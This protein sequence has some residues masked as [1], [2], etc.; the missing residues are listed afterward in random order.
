MYVEPSAGMQVCKGSPNSLI[1]EAPR[2]K[3]L[4]TEGIHKLIVDNHYG[5]SLKPGAA[6]VSAQD[7]A[8]VPPYSRELFGMNAW[9]SDFQLL[10]EI[11]DACRFLVQQTVAPPIKSGTRRERLQSQV[12]CGNRTSCR[13]SCEFTSQWAPPETWELWGLT[14]RHI[15]GLVVERTF[16][17]H[18]SLT[19]GV[20]MFQTGNAT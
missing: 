18:Y 12:K 5:H 7:L 8:N 1:E 3:L 4:V 15:N 20:H 10:D 6:L 16:M 14:Q 19:L 11:Y 2:S 9:R 13:C 17:E